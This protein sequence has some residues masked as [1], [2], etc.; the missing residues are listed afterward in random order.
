MGEEKLQA[1][2]QESLAVAT[3]TDAMKPPDLARV[4]IDNHGAA[5]GGDV[6]DRVGER[7]PQVF[8]GLGG[9]SGTPMARRT[10]VYEGS[11]REILGRAGG[12]CD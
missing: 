7:G 12:W 11:T 8:V 5:E 10:A 6:P 9:V 4:V 3:R 1:L 2:L